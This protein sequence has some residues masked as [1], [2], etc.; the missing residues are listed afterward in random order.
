MPYLVSMGNT[1][2]SNDASEA[3]TVL[4]EAFAKK[5]GNESQRDFVTATM[6]DFLGF[7]AEDQLADHGFNGK[8]ELGADGEPSLSE[9][10]TRRHVVEGFWENIV[11]GL[12]HESSQEKL[13]PKRLLEELSG[14]LRFFVGLIIPR[15]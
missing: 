4:K 2:G 1:H 15:I 13:A 9:K 10:Y 14:N 5:L 8:V 7:C 6:S 12:G 3:T 11:A